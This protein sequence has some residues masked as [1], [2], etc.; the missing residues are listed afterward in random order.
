ML[1]RWNRRW[2]LR[3]HVASVVVALTLAA[4]VAGVRRDELREA[5]PVFGPMQRIAFSADERI[6]AGVF[7]DDGTALRILT[8]TR[9]VNVWA[10]VVYFWPELLGGLSAIAA[11]ACVRRVLIVRRNPQIVGAPYCRKCNY[12]LTGQISNRCPEC[13]ALTSRMASGRRSTRRFLLPVFVLL[14]FAIPYATLCA[15]RVPRQGTACDWLHWWS[16]DIDAWSWAT[17]RPKAAWTQDVVAVTSIV[18]QTGSRTTQIVAPR[19]P[20]QHAVALT[21]DGAGVIVERLQNQSLELIDTGSGKTLHRICPSD[22]LVTPRLSSS[23]KLAGFSEDGAYAY[24]AFESAGQRT[25]LMEW[26]LRT[27]S[28]RSVLESHGGSA[29]YFCIPGESKPRFVERFTPGGPT[30]FRSSWIVRTHE[31]NFGGDVLTWTVSVR[32]WPWT[33]LPGTNNDGLYMVERSRI[34]KLEPTTALACVWIKAPEGREI[35][36]SAMAD[37]ESR[38]LITAAERPSSLFMPMGRVASRFLAFDLVHRRA[39]GKFEHPVPTQLLSAHRVLSI[40]ADRLYFATRHSELDR[41]TG[42]VTLNEVAIFDLKP[43]LP[44]LSEP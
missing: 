15:L 32:D 29:T 33:I 21:P 10:L 39:I 26:N 12:C 31:I 30:F 11:V 28:S 23:G 36:W 44:R 13:G 6:V 42:A 25:D 1:F 18:V 43:I 20:L 4:S 27:G 22:A 40:S 34:V 9:A 37:R 38:L 17:Y 7:S 16:I 41:K 35:G 5:L 24:V 8:E 3:A 19:L 2:P 14:A